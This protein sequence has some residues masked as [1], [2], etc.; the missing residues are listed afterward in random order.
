MEIN[1][2][3]KSTIKR[4]RNIV[5]S[6]LGTESSKGRVNITIANWLTIF[7]LLLVP[8]FCVCFF[9]GDPSLLIMSTFIFVVAALTDILDG[10]L[11]RQRGEVTAFG[12]FMDP[13]A[14][15]LLVLTAFWSLVIREDFGSLY[16]SAL[17]LVVLITLREI[18]LTLLRIWAISGG[19]SVVTSIWGKW[20]TGVQLTTLIFALVML[21]LRDTLAALHLKI[22]V[23]ESFGFSALITGL[24]FLSALTSLISGS[25]YIISSF[26]ARK[27]GQPSS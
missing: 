6:I 27:G 3:I 12:D 4:N 11:A 18:G 2:E 1:S 22:S 23:F 24:I 13:L 15:K 20:K 9:S 14:D 10:K 17:V 21:N 25:M 16:M 5:G 19:S 7:R 8:A 26:N